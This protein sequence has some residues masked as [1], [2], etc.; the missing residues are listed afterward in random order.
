VFL[1]HTR[2]LRNLPPERSFVAAAEAA[3]L[4]A[5]CA[6]TDMEYFTARDR[7]PADYCTEMVAGADVYVGVV[8]FRYGSPVRDRPELSYTELEFETASRL[9]LPRLVFL[10][11][12]RAAP[13]AIAESSTE[14]DGGERQ[15][16]FRRRLMRDRALTIRLVGNPTE[17]ELRLHQALVELAVDGASPAVRWVPPFG[18]RRQRSP[19]LVEL[20]RAR[21]DLLD[22]VRRIWVRELDGSLYRIARIELGLTERPSA[23]ET[24]RRAFLRR[25]GQPDRPIDRRTPI[26]EVFGD[27]GR[28]LLVLGEPGAGKTTL[29]LELTQQLLDEAR[30]DSGSR[31]PVV[32][33]LSSWSTER[34]SLDVWLVDEL[35]RRYGVPRQLSKLWFETDEI[36]PMLDGLDEVAAVQRDACVMAI[37]D[38][39]RN[40]GQLPIVVCSRTEEYEQL[41]GRL[42]LRGAIVIEPL[43]R[44]EVGDYLRQTG[45]RLV[46]VHAAL[47]QD[48]QLW[49]LLTTPLFLSI[50]ALTYQNRS[51]PAMGDSIDERRELMLQDYV[52]EMLSRPRAAGRSGRDTRRWLGRLAHAMRSRHESVFYPDWIQPDLLSTRWQRRL[53]TVGPAVTVGLLMGPIGVPVSGAILGLVTPVVDFGMSFGIVGGVV[54]SICVGLGFGLA[55]YEDSI[56]PASELRWSWPTVRRTLPGWLLVGVVSGLALGVVVAVPGWISLGPMALVAA[57]PGGVI[58][59]IGLSLFLGSVGGLETRL[60]IRDAVPG[61]A[62][63]VSK[64][65]AFVSGLT[66]LVAGSLNAG[67]PFAGILALAG[68]VRGHISPALGL[69]AGLVSGLAIGL[70]GSVLLRL[71]I[72][73]GTGR[74]SQLIAGAGSAAIGGFAGTL[75]LAAVDSRLGALE[76]GVICGS[77]AAVVVG[78]QRGGTT[79][80]RHHMLRWM[81]ARQHLL[82]V[83]LNDFLEYGASVILLRRRGAGYEFVHSLLLDHFAAQAE[84]RAQN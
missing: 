28:Q 11:D 46:R 39:H 56:S 66:S 70:T 5:G 51:L 81:L 50:V 73:L 72:G 74:R 71:D 59:G 17:L 12:E 83:G 19:T 15:T 82:P 63:R 18:A 54:L 68:L 84:R 52:D 16:A 48:V 61:R 30:P 65:N 32:F 79:Y 55:A 24:P 69:T 53:I 1:S 3:V 23:V 29:L 20:N 31:M 45:E 67:V 75:S 26:V 9:G 62:I 78:L 4:S 35:H 57:L 33:N 10:L 25:E 37:N 2:E 80:L 44:D 34:P 22:E 36:L 21:R 76:F 41:R 49:D 64:R 14:Y 13:L 60:D 38:F 42:E 8:G 43:T 47:E 6:V 27:L 58:S 77:A 7:A 40:H